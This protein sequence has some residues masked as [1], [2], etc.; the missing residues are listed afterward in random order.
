MP[1]APA[2]LP[3]PLPLP[4]T[5]GDSSRRA[6]E[7]KRALAGDQSRVNKSR[8]VQKPRQEAGASVRVSRGPL[9]HR[10]RRGKHEPCAGMPTPP[11]DSPPASSQEF[12]QS[13]PHKSAAI[14]FVLNLEDYTCRWRPFVE[15][16]RS[17]HL[18]YLRLEDLRVAS[19]F[20]LSSQS[21]TAGP[22]I[23]TRAGR[24]SRSN[25]NKSSAWPWHGHGSSEYA[26]LGAERGRRD[27]PL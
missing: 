26:G 1:A 17:A 20:Y 23:P 15:S 7:R 22:K 6:R 5:E 12:T 2:S 9:R 25:K 19:P 10:E 13:G 14:C 8:E 18:F 16:K 11:P 4:E 24:C 21:L 27:S 3:L